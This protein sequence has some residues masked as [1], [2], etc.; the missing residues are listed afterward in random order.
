[1][2]DEIAQKSERMSVR[3]ATGALSDVY[4]S[5]SARVDDYIR[6]LHVEPGQTGAVFAVDGKIEGLELFDSPET[7]SKMSEKLVRSYA[8][9]ALE[10]AGSPSAVPSIS[11][12][13]A[14]LKEL[15]DGQVQQYS[16]V[17]LGEEIRINSRS[18][19]AG[20]LCV[21]ETLVHLVAFRKQCR[22]ES[23]QQSRSEMLRASLRRR[24]RG[25][26]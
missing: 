11:E 2:W 5:H 16:A 17:G 24:N 26:Q 1:V 9:D 21:D 12:A 14:F 6:R 7:F 18:L 13:Q 10:T 23:P 4:E 20:G 22:D 25:N 15:A 3:S 8:L 19:V